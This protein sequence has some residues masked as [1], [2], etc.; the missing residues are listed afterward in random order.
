LNTPAAPDKNPAIPVEVCIHSKDDAY[1]SR[2]VSSAWQGGAGRIELC[3]H[4]E[5]DG[6]TPSVKHI[7]LAR[8]AFRD[9]PGLLPMIRPRGGDFFYHRDDIALMEQQIKA[10][11]R[12]GADGVV[13]GVLDQETSAVHKPYSER[14]VGMAREHGL[15]VSFHRAFDA[16]SDWQYALD[17]LLGLGIDRVLT[18]GMPWGSAGTALDGVERLV[19][20]AAFVGGEIEIVAGGGVAIDNG[21]AIVSALTGKRCSLHAYSSMLTDGEVS[22]QKVQQLVS[23]TA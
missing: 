21:P 12:A 2:S 18:S 20:M 1:V 22:P 10:A 16:A 7:E 17:T 9:R 13:I 19:Q 15:S 14:L 3:A 5:Q 6:L 4:M 11:A 8:E 23:L